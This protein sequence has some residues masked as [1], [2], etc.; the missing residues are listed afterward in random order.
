[1]AAAALVLVAVL[2]ARAGAATFCVHQPSG[3]CGAGQVDKGADLQGALD[4]ALAAN[5]ADTVL[6]GAGTY[7][8]PFYYGGLEA[9]DIRG[10]GNATVLQAP[11]GDG[12][13]VLDLFSVAAS[14]S[15]LRIHVPV[16]NSGQYNVGLQSRGSASGVV[17]VIPP[18][19]TGPTVGVQLDGGS[20]RRGSVTGPTQ[21][22]PGYYTLALATGISAP[23]LGRGREARSPSR[24]A[25]RADALGLSTGAS[26][27][28]ARATASRSY[29]SGNENVRPSIPTSR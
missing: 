24:Q 6:V 16:G 18:N 10:A 9:V 23:A 15:N 8:G 4:D 12:V 27:S 25:M 22:F 20:F 7:T 21:E 11:G 3:G 2:P 5:G 26:V 17:V 29:T 13:K 14:V 19:P 1:V 28:P